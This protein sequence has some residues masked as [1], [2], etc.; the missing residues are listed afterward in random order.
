MNIEISWQICEKYSNKSFMKIC[1]VG[2]GF[3]HEDV[4]TKRKIDIKKFV[5]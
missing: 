4:Q 3:F 1:P 2:A 5:F